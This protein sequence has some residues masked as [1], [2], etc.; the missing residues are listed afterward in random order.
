VRR[1]GRAG[2]VLGQRIGAALLAWRSRP[3]ARL[4]LT[5]GRIGGRRAEALAMEEDLLA[6]GVPQG[7]LMLEP[8]SRDTFQSAVA[9]AALLRQLPDLGD[10]LVCSSD[11]HL[12]RCRML[13]ALQGFPSDAVTARSRRSGILDARFL[14]SVA[15]EG[16]AL[17]YD[18]LLM[19]WHRARHRARRRPA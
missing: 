4:L 1:N 6:A 11:F 8:E 5:G 18:T 16:L 2:R 19:L 3:D 15:R 14:C 13:M 12:P 10:V 9:C 7:A 17:P